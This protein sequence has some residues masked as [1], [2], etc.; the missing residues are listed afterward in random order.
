MTTK[1]GDLVLP[2]MIALAG[3]VIMILT[4]LLE[5]G[6]ALLGIGLLLIAVGIGVYFYARE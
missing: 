5:H 4:I 6:A 3:I 2:N 1:A